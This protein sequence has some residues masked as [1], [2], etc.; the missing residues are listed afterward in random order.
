MERSQSDEEAAVEAADEL[1]LEQL[2]DLAA[3]LD[4]TP[5]YV[6]ARARAVFRQVTRT[7]VGWRDRGAASGHSGASSTGRAS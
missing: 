1:L 7:G 2:T 5:R 4:P 6:E 3:T